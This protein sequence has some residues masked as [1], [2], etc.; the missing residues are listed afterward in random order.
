MNLLLA[1]VYQVAAAL[2]LGGKKK[3]QIVVLRRWDSTSMESRLKSDAH[4]PV[5]TLMTTP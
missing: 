5:H 2:D 4:I 1:R 3:N